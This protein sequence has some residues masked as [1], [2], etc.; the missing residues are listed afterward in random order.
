MRPLFLGTYARYSF[1]IDLLKKKKYKNILEIGSGLYGISDYFSTH[2]TGID[3]TTAP[4]KNRSQRMNFIHG[5]ALALKEKDNSYDF[6][7]STD[8]LEHIDNKQRIVAIKEA[9]RVSSTMCVIGFPCGKLA[10]LH[11]DL[12]F[13]YLEMSDKNWKNGRHAWLIEHIENGLPSYED[14]NQLTEDISGLGYSCSPV[15]TNNIIGWKNIIGLEMLLLKWGYFGLLLSTIFVGIAKIFR[16]RFVC[17]PQLG[18]RAFL[19]IHKK[20]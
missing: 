13:N 17:Q 2:F 19:V 20:R 11:D 10:Q 7:F 5:D 14:L 8:M 16:P 6:V 9:I 15:W 12:L 18:Y 4:S 3:S 1:I